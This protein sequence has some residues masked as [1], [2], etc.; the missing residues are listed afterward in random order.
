MKLDVA[1]IG[2]I[3]SRNLRPTVRCNGVTGHW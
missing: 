2:V 3:G 1:V